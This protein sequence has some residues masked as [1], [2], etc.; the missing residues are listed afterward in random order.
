[1]AE[2]DVEQLLGSPS[3]VDVNEYFITWYYGYPSGGRV[4]FDAE[5]RIVEGWTEP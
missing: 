5:Q 2:S 3:K 1:M 4:Q